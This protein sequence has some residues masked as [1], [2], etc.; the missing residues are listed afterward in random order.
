MRAWRDALPAS[1]PESAALR[2]GTDLLARWSEPQRHYH[3]VD[4][5]I[6]VLEIVDG[7][8]ERAADP[9][10]VRLA[11]WF[12]DAIY[13]PLRMDNEEASALLAESVLPGLGVSHVQLAEVARLVRL[14]ASHDPVPGDRNG[15]LLMDAD[16]AIL[17]SPQDRYRA[18]V[19]AVRR[20]Y[21]HLDDAVFAVGRAGVLNNLL[22]LPRLFHTPELRE[23][24]EDA[25][26][27]N[28]SCEVAAIRVELGK[29]GSAD[30]TIAE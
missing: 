21:A 13:D 16:L 18:Y 14:T 25:A 10:A 22:S 4:H 28:L 26:R 11:A 2:T 6:T 17:A 15:G 20:E 12:H 8:A 30:L 19:T 3:T 29:T 7:N 1:A 23:M 9:D 27:H 24:W 5:L